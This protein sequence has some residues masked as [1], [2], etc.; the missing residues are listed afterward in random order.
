MVMDYV[1]GPNCLQT[2]K[3]TPNGLQWR[4]ATE[5]IRQAAL[6]LGYAAGRDVIHRDVKPSNLMIDSSGRVRVTDLGLAK[7]TVKGVV[8]LTQEFHT[9]GTPSY[10]SPEQ[11]R[12][13][14]DLDVRSD[15]YSLG[16]TFYHLLCGR[17][18]FAGEGP[19]DVVAKHLTERLVPPIEVKPDIPKDLSAIVCKM[20][21]KSP[22]S[23]YQ[24][25]DELCQDLQ[26]VLEGH[27]VT[28]TGLEA[29]AASSEE[30]AELQQI[31]D[32]LN[33]Q[34]SLE[35]EDAEPAVK[36]PKPEGAEAAP[37]SAP[38]LDPFGPGDQVTYKLPESVDVD[39]AVMARTRPAEPKTNVGLIIALAVFCLLV[40]LAVVL[41]GV[42]HSR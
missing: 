33:L 5:V 31:L 35:I 22:G 38:K 37:A 2:I 16:A 12:S 42:L 24:N 13:A 20:M 15:I 9:V 28:A 19:M 1:D 25:Y 3:E 40:L 36:Q 14:T 26:N 30:K 23:R 7:M 11:I 27:E 4:E 10:M 29:V 17:P 34:A 8:E 6:G 18:P 32:E 41:G 39:T 21:A